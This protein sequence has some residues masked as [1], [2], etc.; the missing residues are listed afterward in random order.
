MRFFYS[1]RES[2]KKGWSDLKVSL[3]NNI[4]RLYGELFAY[5]F[6]ARSKNIYN[7]MIVT[8]LVFCSF[9]LG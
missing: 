1:K 9:Y 8:F 7:K 3:D 6:G 2:D 4:V 5:N